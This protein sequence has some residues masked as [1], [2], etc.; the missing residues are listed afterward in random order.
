MNL[1]A[2]ETP[3]EAEEA[4]WLAAAM[5]RLDVQRERVKH[6]FVHVRLAAD[7]LSHPWH[8]NL[9]VNEL[10]QVSVDGG[11]WHGTADFYNDGDGRGCWKL[12]F[13]YNA[14][15]SLLKTTVYKQIQDTGTYLSIES[16]KSNQWNSMLILKDA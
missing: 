2:A 5:L 1:D 9:D 3:L 12:S 13:H 10:L 15:T 7:W 8:L 14:D 16:K 6:S 11:D 4:D